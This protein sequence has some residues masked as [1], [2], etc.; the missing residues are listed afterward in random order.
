VHRSEILCVQIGAG[1]VKG[2]EPSD[3]RPL[4]S[5][6]IPAITRQDAAGAD[7]SLSRVA[8]PNQGATFTMWR[9]PYHDTHSVPTPVRRCDLIATRANLPLVGIPLQ[10]RIQSKPSGPLCP[11]HTQPNSGH[12]WVTTVKLSAGLLLGTWRTTSSAN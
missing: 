8:I 6:D 5:L 7:H 12:L 9:H 4:E 2:L 3:L 10:S 1:V 11:A